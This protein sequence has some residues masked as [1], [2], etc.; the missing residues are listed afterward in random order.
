MYVEASSKIEAEW[1]ELGSASLKPPPIVHAQ[2][3]PFSKIS[4]LY[5][6]V[7]LAK[8]MQQPSSF[9]KFIWRS[10][11]PNVKRVRRVLSLLGKDLDDETATCSFKLLSDKFTEYC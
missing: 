4:Y 7:L 10:G 11:P 3:L 2:H 6:V 5:V 8:I 1:S 9:Q